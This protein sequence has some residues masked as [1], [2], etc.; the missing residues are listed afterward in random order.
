MSTLSI[1]P[2]EYIRLHAHYEWG[3]TRVLR[4]LVKK[5]FASS[6][7]VAAI[8]VLLLTVVF[9]IISCIIVV[10]SALLAA[11]YDAAITEIVVAPIQALPIGM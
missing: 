7:Q 1:Q 4:S 3:W 5:V 11:S 2:S 8:T 9:V 10:Q 6:E